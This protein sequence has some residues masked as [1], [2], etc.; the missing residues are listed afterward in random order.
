[1]CFYY[2]LSHCRGPKYIHG[3]KTNCAVW[4]HIFCFSSRQ[5]QQT[6]V[7]GPVPKP[8][9]RLRESRP[10]PRSRWEACA[11][12]HLEASEATFGC[13]SITGVTRDFSASDYFS[14]NFNLDQ[15][16]KRQ[17]QRGKKIYFTAGRR[18]RARETEF[19]GGSSHAPQQRC[20]SRL[21][22]ISC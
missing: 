5:L 20:P 8:S 9:P 1:M 4:E 11:P 16:T 21:L 7:L 14:R 22:G 2:F 10:R 3:T 15:V 19:H 6:A 13:S 18:W 12:S 17:R